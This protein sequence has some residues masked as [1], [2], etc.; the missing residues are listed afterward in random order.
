[1]D[2]DTYKGPKV[3]DLGTFNAA[4]SPRSAVSHKMHDIAENVG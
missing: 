3:W 1:M 4:T 2:L